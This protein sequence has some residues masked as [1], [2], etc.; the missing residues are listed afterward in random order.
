MIQHGDMS[1]LL[2]LPPDLVA[3]ICRQVTDKTHVRQACRGLR[4]IVDALITRVN[5]SHPPLPSPLVDATG[6][7]F[8][9]ASSVVAMS[10]GMEGCHVSRWCTICNKSHCITD[11]TPQANKLFAKI[12]VLVPQSTMQSM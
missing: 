9:V 8:C 12:L 10:D 2:E 5:V 6:V 7:L 1:T 11:R 4:V 3:R